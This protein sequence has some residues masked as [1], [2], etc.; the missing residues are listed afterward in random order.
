MFPRSNAERLRQGFGYDDQ[1]VRPSYRETNLNPFEPPN[2]EDKRP[3]PP[4]LLAELLTAPVVGMFV[5]SLLVALLVAIVAW[6]VSP[7]PPR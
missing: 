5:L 4:S 7:V 6:L 1:P 3:A 2:D